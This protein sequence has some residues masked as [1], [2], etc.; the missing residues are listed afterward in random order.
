MF[1]FQSLKDIL[2]VRAK[3]MTQTTQHV[4][5]FHKSNIYKFVICAV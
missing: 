1:I 3:A 4:S 2:N 5:V